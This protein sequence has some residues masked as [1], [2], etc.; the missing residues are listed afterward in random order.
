MRVLEFAFDS[1]DGSGSV[2]LPHSYSRDC[3]AYAGT[4]DNDTALGWLSQ[5]R[6]EDAQLARDYLGL[7]EGEGEGWGMM[8]GIWSSVADVAIVQMQ[9][10]LSLG[11]EARMNTPSTVGENWKW[12]APA[13]YAT[14]ELMGRLRRQAELCER[15]PA[16]DSR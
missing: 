4:H 14:P 7:S 11:G 2:Y 13:G 3:V 5:A 6:P 8:R 12:R 16:P 15:A 10:V 1:I 9:D